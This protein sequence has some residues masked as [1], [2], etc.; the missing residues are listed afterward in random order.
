VNVTVWQDPCEL[1]LV[2]VVVVEVVVEVVVVEVVVDVVVDVVLVDVVVVVTVVE[3]LV[4][5]GEYVSKY[6]PKRPATLVLLDR[7]NPP[8]LKLM[9]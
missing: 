2:D 5:V 1:K 4:V 7:K 9:K 3:V 6:V 8:L